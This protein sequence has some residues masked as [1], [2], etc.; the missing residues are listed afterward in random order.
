[1]AAAAVLVESSDDLLLKV[2]SIFELEE[3]LRLTTV[4]KRW[5]RLLLADLRFP[6]WHIWRA[7]SLVRRVGSGVRVLDVS[8]IADYCLRFEQ[9]ENPPILLSALLR[10]L[11]GGAGAELRTLVSWAPADWNDGGND[12][13]TERIAGLLAV[14]LTL[15]QAVQLRAACPHLDSS[16]R[17]AVRASG[18]A[19]AVAL[20]DALPGR[21]DLLL[22]PPSP[23]PAPIPGDEAAALAALVRHPR[24]SGLSL[25]RS[26]SDDKALIG[27]WVDAALDSLVDALN[28]P[29]GCVLEH[30]A[31]D[32]AAADARDDVAPPQTE[33]LPAPVAEAPGAAAAANGA[34]GL[35]S[36]S[37]LDG[38]RS[39]H[40]HG[41]LTASRGTLRH[42]HF[43]PWHPDADED[44]PLLDEVIRLIS[45]SPLESLA[46]A[47]RDQ[48]A[49]SQAPAVLAIA[50]LL[51]ARDCRLRTVA[52][53]LLNIPGLA[54]LS[55]ADSPAPGDEPASNPFSVLLNALSSNR[56]LR[57]IDA[58]T[59]QW[60]DSHA[61]LL[62]SALCVRAAPLDSLRIKTIYG[63]WLPTGAPLRPLAL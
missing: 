37:L 15:D 44:A 50:S 35:R 14:S 2:M 45:A 48:G 18:A 46:I 19:Q 8:G 52:L 25:H 26:E 62:G 42:L 17:L 30:L 53:G 61:A 12:R 39:R 29:G 5:H 36:F 28:G 10:V 34:C 54:L 51:A 6:S 21:H 23:L 49:S 38:I 63:V 13:G 40:L 59:M 9:K 20:L 22:S 55:P 31:V 47:F 16:S 24:L 56:S 27:P 11:S 3:R 32:V 33:P 4:S 1:M 41:V 57:V 58:S 60:S 43:E 7:P